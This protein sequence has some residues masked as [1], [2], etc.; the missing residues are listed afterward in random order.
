MSIYKNLKS[1]ERKLR[2]SYKRELELQ[3]KLNAEK[4]NDSE[5]LLTL[6]QIVQKIL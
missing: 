4:L 2:E 1:L 5:R 6:R 3:K